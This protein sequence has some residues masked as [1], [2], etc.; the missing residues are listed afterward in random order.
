MLVL[1]GPW[2]REAPGNVLLKLTSS[3]QKTKQMVLVNLRGLSDCCGGPDMIFLKIYP[4]LSKVVLSLF[5]FLLKMI[6]WNG[7]YVFREFHSRCHGPYS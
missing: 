6:F 3:V 5:Q 2:G 7:L 1:S 4:V